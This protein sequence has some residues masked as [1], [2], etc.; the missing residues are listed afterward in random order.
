MGPRPLDRV[1][2]DWVVPASSQ[3]QVLP[4]QPSPYESNIVNGKHVLEAV[5]SMVAR[6]IKFGGVW[7]IVE[8]TEE[9]LLLKK[10]KI[11]EPCIP[12]QEHVGNIAGERY[13]E[14][15]DRGGGPG[16]EKTDSTRRMLRNPR[17]RQYVVRRP[18]IA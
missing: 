2:E 9:Q 16:G 13:E 5:P 18:A 1:P 4:F 14:D 15:H 6:T 8:V 7:L 17:H 3:Y 12:T 11:K 10:G